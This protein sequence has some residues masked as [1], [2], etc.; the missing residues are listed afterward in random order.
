LEQL[1]VL[2]GADENILLNMF[3]LLL[4]LLQLLHYNNVITLNQFS[5]F[6]RNIKDKG[7]TIL[8]YLSALKLSFARAPAGLGQ[9]CS[10]ELFNLT[11]VCKDFVNDLGKIGAELRSHLIQIIN[12]NPSNLVFLKDGAVLDDI[13]I[14]SALQE[15]LIIV[16][17]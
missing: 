12:A 5:S 14:Q 8:K 11:P 1:N 16:I 9:T 10:G 6:I 3:N 13:G 7:R 4:E 2:I 17:K 15:L